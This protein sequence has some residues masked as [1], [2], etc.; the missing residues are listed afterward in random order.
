MLTKKISHKLIFAVSCVTLS[1]IAFFSYVIITS[2]SAELLAQVKHGANQ[3]SET[4][5]SSTKND[6]LLNN[7]RNVHRIIDMISRQ[8]GIEKIRIYN[9]EG[10]IIYSPDPNE[11]GNAVDKRAEACYACH[12]A[13]QPLE[14]LSIS[15]KSRIFTGPDGERNLGIINPIYNEPR[16][17][18]GDCHAHEEDQKVLGVLD[19][20]VSLKEVDRQ[21]HAT[22][23]NLLVFAGT[24]ILFVSVLLWVAVQRL[25]GRPVSRLVEATKRVADGDLNYQISK[26]SRDELGNLAQ[27]FNEM[28]AKL[29]DAQRQIYQQDKLASLGRLAAGV[30]H[31]INNP[32][33]GILAY[34]S[35]LLKRLP[36]DDP[37][38]NDLNVIM[39]ETVRC[40]SIVKNM[41]DFARPAPPS[42]ERIQVNEVIERTLTIAK[43]ECKRARVVVET[44][45][46]ADL[47]PVL[48]DPGQIEQVLLNLVVNALDAMPDA[49]GNLSISTVLDQHS[50]ESRGQV[51]IS[52]SD[53]GH[54]IA[55]EQLDKIFEP[56]YSTK[57]AQG[58]GLGLS[59]AWGIINNHGGTISVTSD[60]G[61]GTT[62][63]I[64]LPTA[65]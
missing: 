24:I 23:L 57:G 35:L 43:Q 31:E 47:P 4:I 7:R 64:R 52:I 1:S 34:S 26:H 20:T 41:L 58:T 55:K 18:T 44:N 40:R 56:F 9:K 54:G 62:F 33:T 27:A 42:K 11:I 22:R 48:A 63:F 38:F 51:V 61:R 60:Q 37:S 3:L 59:V 5:K 53:S 2:H 17:W 19:I 49:G 8:Q 30:A 6:M 65:Q 12:T 15:E 32:L 46:A 25:I 28:T 45:L 14:R 13:N 36:K 21:L 29:S 16:C 10:E 39:Q 50:A